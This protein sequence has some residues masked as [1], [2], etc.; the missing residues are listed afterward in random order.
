[1]LEVVGEAYAAG[2]AAH[3]AAAVPV[4]KHRHEQATGE[5]AAPAAREKELLHLLQTGTLECSSRPTP[6]HPP[7]PAAVGTWVAYHPRSSLA[8][9]GM[10]E[11]VEE[12]PKPADPAAVAVAVVALAAAAAAAAD[13][14][15]PSDSAQQGG[16][17]RASSWTA[18]L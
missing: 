18:C 10:V 5:L 8:R 6:S 16:W 12:E 13:P 4:Q 1:M 3:A 7:N 14:C 15:W 2:A 9:P 11:L 17:Q